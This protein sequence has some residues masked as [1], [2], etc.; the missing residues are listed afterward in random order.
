MSPLQKHIPFTISAAQATPWVECGDYPWVSVH[1]LTQGGSSTVTFQTSNDGVNPV[2]TALGISTAAVLVT[3]TTSAGAV[4]AGPLSGKFFRLNI[5][6]IASGIT[7]GV[8]AF[9]PTP[10]ALSAVGGTGAS[11][12]QVQGN[13]ASAATDSG[14]PVKVAG[15]YNTSLPT[16]TNGQRGDLQVS[17]N[18]NLRTMLV[19]V[20]VTGS[21]GAANTSLASPSSDS[22]HGST[23]RLLTSGGFALNAS[24]LWDRIRSGIITPTATL[25]G[26]QNSLPW[27][28]YNAAPTTRTEGQGGPLQAT[29]DGAQ[30]GK[31]YAAADRDW[32]YA[33]AA[34]GIVN[35]TTAVTFKAAHA[36]LRNYVTSIQVMAEA[37]GAA[38]ELAIR[39]GAGGA[40]LWRTKIGT[41]GVTGGISIVFPNPLK[42]TANT[43]LEVVTLTAS[44]TGAVYFNATG[45]EGA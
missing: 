41:G 44:V 27:A 16:F 31:P 37:L 25:T 10:R 28:V 38:T 9:L 33:A 24:S 12:D 36:T 6:G 29:A 26:H 13:V 20:A 35:T 18:G 1:I 11:A 4:Y 7:S 40:V 30:V 2:S 42:G 15:V 3:S 32:T 34:S 39:D 22:A 14:N 21:D 17:A 23:Q 43:L 19:G 8:V 45:Y 5:T